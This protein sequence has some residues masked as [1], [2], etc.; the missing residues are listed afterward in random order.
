MLAEDSAL[1]D[2]TDLRAAAGGHTGSFSRLVERH[3]DAVYRLARALT[4]SDSEAEDA[5]QETF[6]AAY[7]HAVTFRGDAAVRTWLL[8]IARNA[9]A[10]QRRRRAG[11]PAAH[12]PLHELGE[13]AG[14]GAD[15][16]PE[17]QLSELERRRELE[18]GLDSLS[19]TDRTVIILRDLEGLNGPETAEVLGLSLAAMKTRLHRARLRLMAAVRAG[20]G[21]AHGT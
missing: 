21:G 11:E 6:L 8:R 19:P 10:R 5:L 1:Q 3:Q 18:R 15:N 17:E 14:W 13:A 20:R 16:D 9:A 7:R 2:L 12:Q 4:A